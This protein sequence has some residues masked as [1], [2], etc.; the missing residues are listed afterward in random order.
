MINTVLFNEISSPRV[1][2]TILVVVVVMDPEQLLRL[3]NPRWGMDDL[4]FDSRALEITR[5]R[6]Q[7]ILRLVKLLL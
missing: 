1:H 6:G 2:T 4:V 7:L 5:E 3:Q